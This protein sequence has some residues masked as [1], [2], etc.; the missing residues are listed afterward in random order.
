[1]GASR[2]IL[3]AG[4]AIPDIARTDQHEAIVDVLTWAAPIAAEADVKLLLEPLNTRVDHP[5]YYLDSTSEGLEIIAK[6][7]H[8]HVK[9]LYDMYHSAI[10]KEVPQEVIGSEIGLVDHVHVADAPGRNEPGTGEISWQRHLGWLQENGYRNYLGLEYF[11]SQPSEYTW[12][13][14]SSFI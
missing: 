13:Y 11:P 4:N 12:R 2:L 1:M 3:Q 10:M 6:V 9:L 14:L 8:P 7:N 5:G